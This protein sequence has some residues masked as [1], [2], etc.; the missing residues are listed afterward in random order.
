MTASNTFAPVPLDTL[1]ASGLLPGAALVTERP[2]A[3]GAITNVAVMAVPDVGPWLRRD[4]LLVTSGSVL[5]RLASV[6]DFVARLD[7]RGVAALAVRLDTG[8]DLP[9]ELTDAAT[10]AGIPVVTFTAACCSGHEISR[11]LDRMAARQIDA[12]LAADHVR[13]ELLS[14]VMAGGGHRELAAALARALG[15]AVLVTTPDGRQIS[16]AGEDADLCRLATSSALD[17]TGR[18][19]T[20]SVEGGLGRRELGDGFIAVSAVS[21]N[22]IDHGRLALF[23]A[24]R[25]LADEELYLVE[26]AAEVCALVVTR[27]LAVAAVE[28]K[29]RA[30][31]VRDLLRGRGGDPDRVVAHA[32]TFGWDLSRPI[33]VLAIEPDP[34][35]TDA[36]AAPNRMPVVERQARA[37][38]GAVAARDPGAVVTAL[39]TETVVLMGEGA[40]T[41]TLVHEL[42]AHVRGAGGGGRRPFGV[43]VSRVSASVDDLPALYSQAR[44]A[45]EVGRRISGEWAVTHFDE[46]GVY[47]LLSLVDE[48]EELESFA[49][50]TLRELTDDTAEAQDM[51][52]TLEVLLATNINIAETARQLHFHYNTL[53]YRVVKLEKMLGPF[54]AHPALRLDLSLALKIIAMRGINS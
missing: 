23:T 36:A 22:G 17:A 49:R 53:R 31:F 48:P 19:R 10:E 50:E 16:R 43:G 34:V 41:M 15:G 38:S 45:L 54:T 25:P 21:A 52:R 39:S 1:L 20:D 47:R 5:A 44:T 35:D 29:H 12:V 8:P 30:N 40:D 42:V 24:S 37:F 26:R 6:S 28:E 3:A 11:S 9:R 27:E 4:Q 32:R 2:A 13:H 33:V 7:R 18:L 46:L 14:V 51:R